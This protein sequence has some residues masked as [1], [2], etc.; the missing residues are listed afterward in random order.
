[1]KINPFKYLVQKKPIGKKFNTK[2]ELHFL[3]PLILETI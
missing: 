2:T 1:M 3:M